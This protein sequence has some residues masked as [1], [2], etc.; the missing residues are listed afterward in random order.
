MGILTEICLGLPLNISQRL[1]LEAQ[2]E[3]L[4]ELEAENKLL[5]ERLKMY[6]GQRGEKCPTCKQPLFELKSR[7]EHAMMPGMGL[8]DYHFACSGCGFEETVTAESSGAAWRLV[9]D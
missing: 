3:R 7:L 8:G 1:K 6:E 9:R 2:E 4:E 5:R